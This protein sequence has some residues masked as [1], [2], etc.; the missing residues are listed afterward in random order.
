MQ[1][2]KIQRQGKNLKESKQAKRNKH[3]YKR[4]FQ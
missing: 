1:S 2:T 4:R 3:I